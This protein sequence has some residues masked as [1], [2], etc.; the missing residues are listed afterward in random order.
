MGVI[1]WRICT[2][3]RGRFP[4]QASSLARRVASVG[5]LYFFF[6]ILATIVPNVPVAKQPE[7]LLVSGSVH[8]WYLAVRL[9][10]RTHDV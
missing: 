1:R 9:M 10:M 3:V 7:F 6:L 8:G 4:D 2:I 5:F